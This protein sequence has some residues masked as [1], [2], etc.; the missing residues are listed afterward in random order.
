MQHLVLD[1]SQRSPAFSPPLK[2]AKLTY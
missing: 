2:S 1:E